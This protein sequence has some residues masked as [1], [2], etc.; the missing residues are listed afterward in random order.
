MKLVEILSARMK[1][2]SGGREV[3]KEVRECVSDAIT[4]SQHSHNLQQRQG[5]RGN[6]SKSNSHSKGNGSLGMYTD[7][8]DA[9]D[10]SSDCDSEGSNIHGNTGSASSKR[11]S[12][13]SN[14]ERDVLDCDDSI[15]VFSS[16]SNHR[17][18]RKTG[19]VHSNGNSSKKGNSNSSSIDNDNDGEGE[20]SPYSPSAGLNAITGWF[21]SHVGS[22]ADDNAEREGGDVMNDGSS[23]GSGQNLD[24]NQWGADDNADNA[25]ID[26]EDMED[27]GPGDAVDFTSPGGSTRR[28]MHAALEASKKASP[29]MQKDGTFRITAEALAQLDLENNCQE[30]LHFLNYHD[31]DNHGQRSGGGGGRYS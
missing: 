22:L 8:G 21:S 23:V 14:K 16:V 30:H 6:S 15:S 19:T 17:Q 5:Q 4:D 20:S 25:S 12:Y 26:R 24:Q 18:Q 2:V 11:S 7:E 13:N 3:M 29:R 31:N 28:N 10:V 9:D 1:K 27:L